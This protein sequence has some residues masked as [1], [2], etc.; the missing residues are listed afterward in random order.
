MGL[1]G[2]RCLLRGAETEKDTPAHYIKS[3]QGI[4]AEKCQYSSQPGIYSKTGQKKS[5]YFKGNDRLRSYCRT[6]V[7]GGNNSCLQCVVLFG[8]RF[9]E[10]IPIKDVSGTTGEA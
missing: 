8:F 9:K 4:S 5:Q 3:N 1:I 6:K 7:Q 10:E 2:F